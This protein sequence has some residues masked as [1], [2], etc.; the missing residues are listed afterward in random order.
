[1]LLSISII[2]FISLALI[3]I[4]FLLGFKI[5]ETSWS[6]KISKPYKWEAAVKEGL[7]SKELMK[8]EGSYRDKVRF[9]NV[10]FQV[11]R[12]KRLKVPGA[13]AE[14]G[15]Y[16]GE[17]AA[18]LHAMDGSR[19][20][21]L[22]DT[23]GGFDAKDLDLEKNKDE[24]YTTSN[25]SDT[26]LEAVQALFANASH[27]VSFYPGYFPD[28][29]KTLS[30]KTFALVHIDAD[31]Y[32]PTIEA[33]KFFYPKVAAGGVLIIHDYNHTWEGIKQAIDEFA[34]TIPESVVEVLDWQGSVM[35][36]KNRK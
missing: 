30:E 19:R 2:Q 26:S 17:T 28:T 24:R 6:Y 21:H 8:I 36:V 7:V 31:L 25:F 15:V 9:Y 1:M 5:M 11:E 10:W 27:A 18:M 16:K 22:F 23:F 33:L 3:V 34:V 4:L 13:F 35:I 32:L 12:L 29:T 20:L 14:L